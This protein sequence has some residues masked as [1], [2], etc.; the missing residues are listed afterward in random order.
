[1]ST[2]TISPCLLKNASQMEISKILLKFLTE[3]R[4]RVA[5]DKGKKAVSKYNEVIL[6]RNEAML[7]EWIR[8]VTD[9]RCYTSVNIGN[10]A[11]KDLFLEICSKTFDR[12]LLVYDKQNLV[13]YARVSVNSINYN[14]TE[15]NI[16]DVGEAMELLSSN[17]KIIIGHVTDSNFTENGDIRQR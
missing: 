14:G 9:M 17:G 4:L 5:L 12:N 1:M 6:C 8:F 13:E 15:I 7:A 11:D 3:D 16:H 2:F 10:V